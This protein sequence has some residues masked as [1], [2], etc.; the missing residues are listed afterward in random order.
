MTD[1]NPN[2]PFGRQPE[3]VHVTFTGDLR[4]VDAY[5]RKISRY[6]EAQG[7]NVERMGNQIRIYPRAVNE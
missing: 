4:D 1:P 2:E 3:V 6:I 7:D 5:I